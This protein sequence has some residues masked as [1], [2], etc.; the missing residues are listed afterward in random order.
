[1]LFVGSL[2]FN[3]ASTQDRWPGPMDLV[4]RYPWLILMLL[5][6][7]AVIGLWPASRP[8]RSTAQVPVDTFRLPARHPNFTGR[9]S[10]LR[11]LRAALTSGGTASVHALHGMGG[12]GK[13]QMSIEYAY[14]HQDRYRF[15]GFIDAERPEI[16][17]S[18]FVAMAGELGI[19]ELQPDRVVGAVYRLLAQ[20]GRWLL[21]FDNGEEPADLVRFL[22]S[23]RAARTGHVIVTTR[24]AGWR[25]R[26]STVDVDLF[27]RAESVDLLVQ[28]VPGLTDA[29]ADRIAELLGDLPLALEQ[30]A[31]FLERTATPPEEYVRLLALRL[32]QMLGHGTVADRPG[33][34]VG[35]LWE[36]NLQQLN[37]TRPAA[38]DLLELCALL[39]PEPIPTELFSRHPTLL[40]EP[41]RS[42]CLDPVEWSA[43]LGD[44]VGLS[45]AR[46]NGHRLVVHRLVQ[47][48]VRSGL[49]PERRQAAQHTLCDLLLA[50]LPADVESGPSRWP[51][52][53]VNLPH[54]ITVAGAAPPSASVATLVNL[55]ARYLRTIGDPISALPMAEQARTVAEAVHGADDA[56]FGS[57]LMTLARIHRDMGRPTFALPL[58]QRTLAI[59]ET[60]LG[61]DH[62]DLGGVLKV[63]AW[64]LD[65]LGRPAEAL[66]FAERALAID[67]TAVGPSHPYVGG[68][69]NILARVNRELG[70]HAE[71]VEQAERALRIYESGYGHDHPY[72]GVV[73]TI[74]ARLHD[75]LGEP[76]RGL[77]LAARAVHIHETA[78]GPDH[79]D[80]GC[81]LTALARLHCQLGQAT[82]ARGLAQRALTILETRRGPDH[83][84]TVDARQALLLAGS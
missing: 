65:D 27:D 52:W 25:A 36:M 79:P 43:V 51:A 2:A 39:A 62:A 66:P 38:V 74:L 7:V 41:V 31:A 49:T 6:P 48:A 44:M 46:R 24:R 17:M 32:D 82:I 45:L 1:M 55:A 42:A 78:Y 57:A 10:A 37:R 34:V 13:T 70:R 75:D 5:A 23:G 56:A 84:E 59:Y 11:R 68:A 28:R 33:V 64:V 22:P 16:L 72:V 3:A 35:R 14:R 81:A 18:Q 63:L 26:G 50:A 77:P 21:I 80:V 15:I 47:A 19:N 9:A 40:D 69:L 71:A 60:Q 73:M 20:R 61:R 76:A 83:Q 30:A 53:Q 8:G 58:A 12:V 29:L 4:R 67:E 54:V